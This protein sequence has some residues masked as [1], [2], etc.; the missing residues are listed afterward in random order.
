MFQFNIWGTRIIS[1]HV[2]TVEISI[3][4]NQD[5]IQCIAPYA[6]MQKEKTLQ[7]FIIRISWELIIAICHKGDNA[8]EHLP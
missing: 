5:L 3:Q 4:R 1:L 8:F 2:I 6:D 7:V